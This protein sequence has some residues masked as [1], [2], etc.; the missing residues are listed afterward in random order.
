M[1]SLFGYL[2]RSAR[3]RLQGEALEKELEEIK[4][5]E[6]DHVEAMFRAEGFT[7]GFDDEVVF[8][9][10]AQKR[11]LECLTRL[12]EQQGFLRVGQ[13]IANAVRDMDRLFYM[14]DEVLGDALEEYERKLKGEKA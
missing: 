12:A 10:P 1:S 7:K 4:Q 2:R 9:D 14:K 8:V 3:A 13:N 5:A 6:I 11:I